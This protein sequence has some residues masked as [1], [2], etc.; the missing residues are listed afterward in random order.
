MD[1]TKSSETHAETFYQALP[2]DARVI[3]RKTFGYPSATVGG[4]MFAS[5]ARPAGEREEG[6]EAE[7]TRGFRGDV[8]LIQN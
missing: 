1:W 5:P 4:H 2:E 3:R 6:G 7:E 8:E